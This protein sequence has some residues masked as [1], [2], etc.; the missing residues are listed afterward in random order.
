MTHPKFGTLSVILCPFE[1]SST[2]RSFINFVGSIYISF[3]LECN[4]VIKTT[5]N[6]RFY[7]IIIWIL[8]LGLDVVK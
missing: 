4:F 6:E 1:A 3:V 5:F 2:F 8:R 7:Q